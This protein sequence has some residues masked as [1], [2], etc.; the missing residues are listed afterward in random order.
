MCIFLT[1]QHSHSWLQVNKIIDV[2][3]GYKFAVSQRNKIFKSRC[4]KCQSRLRRVRVKL[5][6]TNV[7]N[8]PNFS[9]FFPISKRNWNLNWIYTDS[10][11]AQIKHAVVVPKHDE[12][13]LA[14]KCLCFVSKL[15]CFA[16]N[17]PKNNANIQNFWRF[18][19][20]RDGKHE[21]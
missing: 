5:R 3:L 4:N 16:L 8:K 11:S 21:F 2:Q 15:I 9:L 14:L 13:W 1:P 19:P 20:L 12:S 17:L 6:T 18:S 10:S 7:A